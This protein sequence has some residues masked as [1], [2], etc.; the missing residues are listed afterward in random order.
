MAYVNRSI[1]DGRYIGQATVDS[2]GAWDD[3]AVTDYASSTTE[4]IPATARLVDLFVYNTSDTAPAYVLLRAHGTKDDADYSGALIVP[5]LSGRGIG[6]NIPDMPITT[7]AVHGTA[8][9][10]MVGV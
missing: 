5:A 10:E 8:R 1:T 4:A 6:V 7:I 3:V 9:V 2:A